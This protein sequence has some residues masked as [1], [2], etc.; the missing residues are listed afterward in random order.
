LQLAVAKESAGELVQAL[1]LLEGLLPMQEEVLGDH[2]DT[3][4]T[5]RRIDELKAKLA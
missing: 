1:E 5:R 2:P 3:Q 4:E